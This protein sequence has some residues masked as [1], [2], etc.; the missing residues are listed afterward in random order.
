MWRVIAMA[1]MRNVPEGRTSSPHLL[2]EFRKGQVVLTRLAGERFRRG[3]GSTGCRLSSFYFARV[4]K[5]TD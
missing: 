3:P 2:L 5:R 1:V 4:E